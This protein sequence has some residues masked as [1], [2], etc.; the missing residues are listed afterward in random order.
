MKLL[1]ISIIIA[2]AIA[3]ARKIYLH[4]KLLDRQHRN[5]VQLGKYLG[6][7]FLFPVFTKYNSQHLRNR[8]HQANFML[9]IFYF[10]GLI[11]LFLMLMKYAE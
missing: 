9:I 7:D 2:G 5:I 11:T 3:M 4:F 1:T 8:K 10:C 6:I